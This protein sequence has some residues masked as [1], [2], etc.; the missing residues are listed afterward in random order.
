MLGKQRFANKKL[1]FSLGSVMVS[2]GVATASQATGS[3]DLYRDADAALYAA[4]DRGRNRVVCF[5]ESMVPD[6]KNWLLYRRGLSTGK[7]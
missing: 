1:G 7:L 6:A 5:D 4:K 3:E 2:M